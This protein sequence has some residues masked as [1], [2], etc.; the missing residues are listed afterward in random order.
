MPQMIVEY[1]DNIQDLDKQ[2]LLL[3]L[4]HAT[5]NTGLIDQP[6][7]IKSRIR[8]NSDYL[9]GFGESNQAYIHVHLY[10]LTGRN[11]AEKKLFAD[12]L[13][14]T[15][16]NFQKY[17]ASGLDVQLCVEVTEMPVVDYRKIVVSK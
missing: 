7:A 11:Q 13:S 6:N 8:V 5:F 1:S 3:D 9:I 17:S 4:N 2:Q 15:L 10:I 14:K 12:D 16:E